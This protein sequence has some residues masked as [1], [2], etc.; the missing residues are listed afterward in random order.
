MKIELSDRFSKN[1]QISNFM[2]IRPVGAELLAD[3]RTA[4]HDKAN[5]RISQFCKRA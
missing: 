2:Q 1:T 5:S 3:G 4:R